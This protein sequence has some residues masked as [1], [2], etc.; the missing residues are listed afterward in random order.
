M[1]DDTT[2]RESFD[3]ITD[4]R[5]RLRHAD[6]DPIATIGKAT[7]IPGWSSKFDVN[8]EEIK[9]WPT[10]WP[11]HRNTGALTKRM[12]CIDIDVL[13]PDAAAAVETV[14]REHCEEHGDIH[15]RFGKAPKRAIPFRTDEPFD[16]I[17]VDLIAPNGDTDQKI[18]FLGSGQQVIVDGI[19]PG[20][21]KPYSW[22]GGSLC[23]ARREDLPYIREAEARELVD[24]AV[25]MLC[26]QFGYQRAAARPKDRA[27]NGDAGAG[28][29][30]D[31]QFL[32]DSIRNGH[33]IHDSLRDLAAKLIAAGMKA[34][35]A[36]NMLQAA[37]QGSTAPRDQRWQERF[38][39]IPNLVD[40]A[41]RKFRQPE[42][43]NDAPLFD[44]W[45]RYIVPE[46]PL[47][48]LPE[49]AREYVRSQS[50]VIGCDPAALAMGVLTTFSGALD[51]RFAVK[52]MRNGSWWEHPR[53]WALLVGDPS[54]KKT[55]V[56]NDVTQ[57]LQW[58]ENNLR[59]DYAARLRDYEA[60][61][62]DKSA[63]VAKPDPPVR[64]VVFD[65]TIEKLGDILSRSE[66]GLL[67]KRDEFSG[68]IGGMEKYGG[69]SRG[70]SADRGFWLQAFDGGPHTVDRIG[71]GETYIGNLSVSLI[72]GIQPAKLAELRGLTSDGLL[73][74]FI[75]VMMRASNLAQ[76][77]ASGDDQENYQRLVF[78]LIAA[79]HQNL[80]LSDRALTVMYDLRQRLHELEQ[81]AGGLADGLQTFI[82]KLPG[83]AGR[84]AVILHMAANPDAAP[85]QIDAL[86]VAHVHT[87]VLDF[88]LP[89]AV[90]FY[91][92]AEELTD[93]ERLRKIA[94]W[95]LTSQQEVVA[96]R[97]LTRNVRVLRGVP[98]LDLQKMVS[99]L[100]A[101]GW[102]QPTAHDPG[103]TTWKVSS[104]VAA[105][106][107]RQRQVEE[108]RKARI[109]A[110]M[111]SPRKSEER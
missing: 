20:T 71:R 109:A 30:E 99:P 97:D 75:P 60:A 70:A 56:I 85:Q 94:S 81:A 62:E 46:F 67:V 48:V 27:G 55:P 39:D 4:K 52:M 100:V 103:N 87:L 104:K 91:R 90:E 84:L 73:Q 79:K 1:T 51:H 53:L 24:A 15:V 5:L 34:G 18:E 111:G 77:C 63:D 88:I 102:L 86:R 13:D 40:S 43:P 105:Q 47:H 95:I 54:K 2:G 8:D 26:E 68:W 14:V 107:E 89:H 59:R 16:K 98:L 57:P 76:D 17:T 108:A 6:F 44:P 101:A 10:A 12:P 21:G 64:Y 65:T 80:Y 92:S 7:H 93:G 3:V 37:M 72:G 61:K 23:D 50:I 29:A 9:F 106:F 38:G 83:I 11:D 49:A 36:V 25:E 28:G 110:L 82:G 42:P 45:E 66:H 33:A 35:T 58:H 74:R 41:E 32:F 22:H 96:S 31:W 69:T 78:K 19:H